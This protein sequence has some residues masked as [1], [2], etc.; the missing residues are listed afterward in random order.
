ME[1][2]EWLAKYL[3][4]PVSALLVASGVYL[5][6]LAH[7]VYFR[8]R[9]QLIR[10]GSA[11]LPGAKLL[12]SQFA[13]LFSFQA[14]ASICSAIVIFALNTL[15]PGIYVFLVGLLALGLRRGLLISGLEKHAASARS[16][17]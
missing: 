15:Q 2:V 17:A 13:L 3:Y 16:V 11:E 7:Q 14:V 4:L 9:T 6:W 8:E 5:A 1:T 10:F 12:K